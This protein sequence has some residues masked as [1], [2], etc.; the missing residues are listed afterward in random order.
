MNLLQVQYVQKDKSY[1]V[2]FY[3]LK[4]S[5]DFFSSTDSPITES[6]MLKIEM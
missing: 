3:T 1:K 5:A 2:I 4:I 6:I